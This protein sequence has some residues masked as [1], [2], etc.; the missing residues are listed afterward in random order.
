MTFLTKY[1]KSITRYTWFSCD[2]KTKKVLDYVLLQRCI[3]QYVTECEVKKDVDFDSDHRLL[4]TSLNTPKSKAARWKP[5]FA[6]PKKLN[7]EAL[8]DDET[9]AKFIGKTVELMDWRESISTASKISENLF[10]K[11]LNVL[12]QQKIGSP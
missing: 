12:Y 3:Q 8:R 11:R 9:R 4:V 6:K 10:Q 7:I 1:Y 5:N 2:K